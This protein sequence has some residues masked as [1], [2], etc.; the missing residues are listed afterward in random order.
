MFIISYKVLCLCG[1]R[2]E[3]RTAST[4][5]GPCLSMSQYAPT[6]LYL[7]NVIQ[8]LTVTPHS[9]TLH[10]IS[11]STKTGKIFIILALCFTTVSP[12]IFFPYSFRAVTST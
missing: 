5:A 7:R 12:F 11:I 9:S 3:Y 1:P 8:T 2:C 10:G 4:A 6:L